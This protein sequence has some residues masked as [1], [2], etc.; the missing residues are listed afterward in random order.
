VSRS[1]ILLATRDS[2]RRLRPFAPIRRRYHRHTRH[3]EVRRSASG[4]IVYGRSS[5]RSPRTEKPIS[6]R[7]LASS[8]DGL[9]CR[10]TCLACDLFVISRRRALLHR[11]RRVLIKRRPST[12]RRRPQPSAWTVALM[13][14][15]LTLI[16]CARSR[17]ALEPGD[18]LGLWR[19][20]VPDP[21]SESSLAPAIRRRASVDHRRP[22]IDNKGVSRALHRRRSEPANFS[23]GRRWTS[24]IPATGSRKTAQITAVVST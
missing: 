21:H 9:G 14:Q 10:A 11:T 5:P 6:S 3:R 13:R 2:P 15:A 24:S 1:T 16:V 20:H 23:E 18:N 8:R 19:A 12:S 7:R 22:P 4:T 17:T